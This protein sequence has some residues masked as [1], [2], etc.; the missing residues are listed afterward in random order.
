MKINVKSIS[1]RMLAVALVLVTLFGTLC[2]AAP[3]PVEA[4]SISATGSASTTVTNSSKTYIVTAKTA[5]LRN[6]TS[7]LAGTYATLNKGALITITGSTGN[8]YKVNVDGTTYY[9][10]KNEVAK[11]STHTSGT[12]Y[13]T[14]KSA[15][16]RRGPYD[17]ARTVTT[18]AKGELI[19]VV[20]TLK[21]KYNNTWLIVSYGG[22]LYY[23]Y[24][25]N[26]CKTGKIT[27]RVTA[28][29]NSLSVGNTLKL[30]ASTS[31][32]GLKVTWT[33]SNSSIATVN[34]NGTV[35]GVKP[36]N[37]VIYAKV[38]N[39]VVATYKLSITLKLNVNAVKQTTSYTCSAASSLAILRYYGKSTNTSD[40]TLY[41]SIDGYVYKIVNVL[42]KQLG[43]GTYRY[44]IFTSKSA[45]EAAIINSLKQGAP[46]IARVAFPKEYFNYKSSGHYTTI[47]GIEYDSNGRAWLTL[48]DSYVQNYK[49]NSYT[50]ASAGTVRIP[51]DVLYKYGTYGG[52]SDIYLIYNP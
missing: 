1:K 4:A 24:T 45:Y 6:S 40:R 22:N 17:S 9:I 8:H 41:N 48:V 35:R 28:S 50:N 46:I 32:A 18:L 52:K 26:A 27:L 39:A 25:S 3:V 49:S 19:S 51:L 15:P 43:S 29:T 11:A 10:K 37:V 33:T 5:K 13:Y 7:W 21:N 2:I 30:N 34:S 44:K 31:P 16:L 36:G 38:G 42:N 20:G 23:M 12:W 14:A 47:I